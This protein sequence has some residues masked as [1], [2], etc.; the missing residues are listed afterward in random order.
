M[1]RKLAILLVCIGLA[2]AM[3]WLVYRN[4]RLD[5]KFQSVRVGDSEQ[6]VIQRLGKPSWQ[7]PCGRSFGEPTK[8]CTE[9]LYRNSFAPLIPEY[10]SVRLDERRHVIQTYVY[11][12]P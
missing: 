12:S 4:S 9:F 2:F 8:N 6:Q 7:E 10:W 5:R 11:E 1:N 3:V